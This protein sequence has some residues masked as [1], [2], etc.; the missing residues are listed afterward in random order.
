MTALKY[1]NPMKNKTKKIT[2]KRSFPVTNDLRLH[3][4]ILILRNEQVM[5]DKDLAEL[6]GVTTRRLNEQVKRNLTRFPNDFMFQLS[7]KEKKKVVANCDHLQS[8]KYSA[9]LPFAFTEHG[10]MMLATVLNSPIAVTTSIQ[11]VRAF[12][13][14]REI[15]SGDNDVLKKIKRL[16]KK[17]DAQFKDVFDAIDVLMEEPKP[18]KRSIGFLLIA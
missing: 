12:I 9:A 11:L 14:Y 8:L 17:Y 4:K 3:R 16:E 1:H 18:K 5:I 7:E 13:W 10:V 2:R 15:V 6:Y